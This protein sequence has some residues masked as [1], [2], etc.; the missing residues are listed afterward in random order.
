MYNG[1]TLEKGI[2]SVNPKCF[3]KKLSMTL[4]TGEFHRFRT[5]HFMVTECE[6]LS[7]TVKKKYDLTKPRNEHEVELS[8]HFHFIGNDS[9]KL[10]FKLSLNYLIIFFKIAS[11]PSSPAKDTRT[12]KKGSSKAKAIKQQNGSLI[13][14]DINHAEKMGDYSAIDMTKVISIHLHISCCGKLLIL[15]FIFLK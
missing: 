6:D 9:C 2:S 15:F 14:A 3:Q 5:F 1:G 8:T 12:P 4:P 11:T 13:Y 7:A 10:Y